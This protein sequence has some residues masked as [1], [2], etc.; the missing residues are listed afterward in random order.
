L[1]LLASATVP[2]CYGQAKEHFPASP[3]Q[4]TDSTQVTSAFSWEQ[5]KSGTA[6]ISVW[7]PSEQ[8]QTVSICITDFNQPGRDR[9]FGEVVAIPA[10]A[11]SDPSKLQKLAITRFALKLK[12]GQSSSPPPGMYTGFLVIQDVH[13]AFQPFSKQLTIKVRSPQPAVSKLTTVAWRLV[14]FSSLWRA[15]ARVPLK[16]SDFLPRL[17]DQGTP[18]GFVRNDTGGLATVLWMRT[19]TSPAGG[20]QLAELKIDDLPH[21]G[22][23]DGDISFSKEENETAVLSLDVIAK[24]IIIWPILVI[25]GG[26]YIAFVTKRYLGVLR[27]SWTLRKQEAAVGNAFQDAQKQFTGATQGTSYGRYSFAEDVAKQRNKIRG[28]LVILG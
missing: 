25:V 28:L 15:G 11:G 8:G 6:I 2:K 22:K 16:H 20:S 27:V 13:K 23:Y 17:N 5:L 26:I 24:D 14:P 3:L 1:L 9:A 12:G 21:A 7:N 4:V 18:I 10:V 19:S